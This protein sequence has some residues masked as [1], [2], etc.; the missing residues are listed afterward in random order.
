MHADNRGVGPD[1]AERKVLSGE[2]VPYGQE[3]GSLAVQARTPRG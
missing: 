2:T 3:I 1:S